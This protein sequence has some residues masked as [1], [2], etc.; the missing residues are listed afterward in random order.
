MVRAA[1]GEIAKKRIPGSQGKKPKGCASIGERS[2]EQAIYNFK[3]RA[4]A[5]DRDKIAKS[6]GVCLMRQNRGFAGGARLAHL[7]REPRA[8][9][10]LQSLRGQFPA[11]AAAGRRIHDREIGFIHRETIAARSSCLPISSA[12]TG[13]LIFMEAVRGKSWS[14]TKYPLMRL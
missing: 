1:I 7:Q 10:T 4:I 13:R 14:Q 5:P 12:S 9:Q 3:A 6:R 8:A 11:A 2:R